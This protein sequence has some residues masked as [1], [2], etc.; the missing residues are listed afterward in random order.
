MNLQIGLPFTSVVAS[1]VYNSFIRFCFAFFTLL[2][3]KALNKKTAVDYVE[4]LHFD[5]IL[6]E[7]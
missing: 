2:W 6:Q 1:Q 5:I 4:I 3:K 7:V